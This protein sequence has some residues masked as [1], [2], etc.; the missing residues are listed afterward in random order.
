MGLYCLYQN[1]LVPFERGRAGPLGEGGGA[2]RAR[3][4]LQE[5]GEE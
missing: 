5:D 1:Y 3:S 2:L 4:V